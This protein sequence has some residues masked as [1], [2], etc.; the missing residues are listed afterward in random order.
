LA[1][2]KKTEKAP[3]QYTKRQLSNIQRHKRRQNIILY[4]GIGIIA[5]VV[6]IVLV[7]LYIGEIRPYQ[8]TALKVYDREFNVRYY[9]DAARFGIELY[10]QEYRTQVVDTVIQS[11]PSVVERTELI[12]RAA[13]ELGITVD[14]DEVKADLEESGYSVNDASIDL[15]RTDLMRERLLDEHFSQEI[16]ENA[17]QVNIKVMF[18][19][20]EEQVDDVKVKL[21]AGDNF[22]ELAEDLS[23][24]SYSKYNSEPGWHIEEWL[25]T[26]LGSEVP[27]DY[28]FN[29][30]PGTLSEAIYDADLEKQIGYWIIDVYEREDAEHAYLKGILAGNEQ[31]AEMIKER[32]LDG[33]DFAELAEEFS[34]DED[35]RAQ[36]GVL[37]V[38]AN[39]SRT[40]AIDANVFAP[41]AV[42]TGL[43]GPFADDQVTTKGGYWL[44]NV[45][46]R[47]AGRPIGDEDRSFLE[48]NVYNDWVVRLFEEAEEYIDSSY[49]NLDMTNF[50]NEKLRDEL[51]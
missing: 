11:L 37:G 47:E 1:K 43:I 16:P 5:L 42:D 44:I 30:E 28:A 12:R 20:S 13:E 18:L 19:E 49:L 38:T 10:P 31:E 50:I 9:I 23:L 4:G 48:S 24:Q 6:I 21:S 3:R 14:D 17:D 32:L 22:T 39:G 2:K 15:A 35:S 27:F 26:N 8:Q 40:D 29:S 33:E 34:R 41:D 45:V 36:G 25:D 46:D 7:G 51:F